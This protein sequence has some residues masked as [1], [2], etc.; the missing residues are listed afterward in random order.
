MHRPGERSSRANCWLAALLVTLVAAVL[1]RAAL[2]DHGFNKGNWPFRP[3][4]RPA[5]PDGAAEWAVNTIDQ[6][7]ANELT[8]KGLAP[9][10]P[11]E[12]ATLLRRVTLDLTGLP[13]T[14]EEVEAF[15]ADDSP[16]AYE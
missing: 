9:N 15:L 7:V 8:K 10:Q 3:L 2:A 4:E 6:F 14:P 1:G 11:A 16:L 12:K 5:M 13:P